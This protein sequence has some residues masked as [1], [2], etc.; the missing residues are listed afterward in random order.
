MLCVGNE[1]KKKFFSVKKCLC[2]HCHLLD[3]E[4]QKPH[5]VNQHE[6]DENNEDKNIEKI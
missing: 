1:K 4:I 2:K 6:Q 5:A 3:V